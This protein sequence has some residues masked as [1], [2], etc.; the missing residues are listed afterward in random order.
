[1]YSPKDARRKE[2]YIVRGINYIVR[3]EENYEF[4]FLPTG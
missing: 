3:M 4:S 2:R 1:M